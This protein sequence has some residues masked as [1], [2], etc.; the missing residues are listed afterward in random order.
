MA[1]R[2]APVADPALLGEE[3]DHD[4]ADLLKGAVVPNAVPNLRKMQLQ[5]PQRA[6][7]ASTTLSVQQA[8]AVAQVCLAAAAA[9]HACAR[10]LLTLRDRAW[11]MA[12]AA[13]C[14]W[15]IRW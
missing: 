13:A 2:V 6:A 4:V 14:C 9:L 7:S 15:G 1:V 8:E 10:A 3:G 11:R 12:R 5:L